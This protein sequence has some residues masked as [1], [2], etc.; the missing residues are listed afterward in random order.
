MLFN[1]HTLTHTHTH[2]HTEL[3]IHL[4]PI[5]KTIQVRGN[6]HAGHC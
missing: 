4:P 2:T 5:S 6:R 1:I 3:N